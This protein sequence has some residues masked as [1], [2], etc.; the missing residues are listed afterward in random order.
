M[1]KKV[2][3]IGVSVLFDI[4]TK[5]G[6]AIIQLD[7]QGRTKD[8][9]LRITER[10]VNRVIVLSCIE[11]VNSL[12]EPCEINLYVQTNFGFKFMNNKKKWRNRDLGDKLFEAI[13]QGNHTISYFD[14]SESEAGKRYQGKLKNKLYRY[15]RETLR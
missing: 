10:T 9:F 7:Y 6:N 15:L 14:C 1:N 12:K 11:A 5:Q 2:V 13:Q 4:H 3:T 8:I